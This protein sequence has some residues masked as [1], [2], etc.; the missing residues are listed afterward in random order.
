VPSAVIDGIAR[1]VREL[2]PGARVL[3]SPSEP[4]VGAALLGLDA[5]A[6]DRSAAD[7]ARAELDAAV[8][9]LASGATAAPYI[10]TR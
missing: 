6:G 1:G 3:V 9:N 2:A 10:G 7:R 4:I 8:A 5:I